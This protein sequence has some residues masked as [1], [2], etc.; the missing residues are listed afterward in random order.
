MSTIRRDVQADRERMVRILDE[1]IAFY[2]ADPKGRRATVLNTI[3]CQYETCD[4]RQCIVGRH[5]VDPKGA[6][7]GKLD[8]YELIERNAFK[9]DDMGLSSL[10][11]SRLQAMHDGE[12]VWDDDGMSEVGKREYIQFRGF[13]LGGG[14]DLDDRLKG[15]M[16]NA[17]HDPDGKQV[18]LRG[19]IKYGGYDPDDECDNL[20]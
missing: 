18:Q 9:P 17:G 1:G 7:A 15:F 5:L 14:Y 10:F 16:R 13:I 2:S 3:K 6:E 20:I 8:V 11:W 12:H 4:G 19:F